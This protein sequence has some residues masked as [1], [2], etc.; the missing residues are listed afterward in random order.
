MVV[1]HSTQFLK[2]IIP[3]YISIVIMFSFYFVCYCCYYFVYKKARQKREK[4][5]K[6]NG[7]DTI[8]NNT[9]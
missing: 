6:L 9:T 8:H 4:R 1:D 3:L 5:A 2:D 7:V